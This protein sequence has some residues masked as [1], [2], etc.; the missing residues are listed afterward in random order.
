LQL[1]FVPACRVNDQTVDRRQFKAAG[2]NGVV[3]RE[4]REQ[5]CVQM[6]LAGTGEGDGRGYGSKREGQPDESQ[7]GS[8]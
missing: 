2:V 8:D 3:R 6:A 4:A 5:V 1:L 7:Y